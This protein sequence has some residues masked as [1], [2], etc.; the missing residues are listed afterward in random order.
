MSSTFYV[1][2]ALGLRWH[3]VRNWTEDE[4]NLRWAVAVCGRYPQ[5]VWFQWR[6]NIPHDLCRNCSKGD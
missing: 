1:Q 4:S 5:H 6:S 3:I 2:E